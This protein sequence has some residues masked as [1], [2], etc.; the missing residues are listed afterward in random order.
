MR[1][2][3]SDTH[4]NMGLQTCGTSGGRVSPCQRP[5]AGQGYLKNVSRGERR[6][7]EEQR[8]AS[9]QVATDQVSSTER[10]R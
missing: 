9:R 7:I 1:G 2:K 4:H 8:R 6:A 3:P 5:V 10:R